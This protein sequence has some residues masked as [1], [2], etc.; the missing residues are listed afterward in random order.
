[1]GEKKSVKSPE[2]MRRLTALLDQSDDAIML[3]ASASGQFHDANRTACQ[4]LGYEYDALL[5]TSVAD[6]QGPLAHPWAVALHSALR[7]SPPPRSQTVV[8]NGQNGAPTIFELTLN[9][10]SFNDS[11]YLLVV[12]HEIPPCDLATANTQGGNATSSQTDPRQVLENIAGYAMQLSLA[13]VSCV[14]TFDPNLKFMAS[15]TSE[16]FCK[17]IA[18]YAKDILQHEAHK[19]RLLE[20]QIVPLPDLPGESDSQLEA[21][22]AK[23]DLH[24]A[25]FVPIPR[26]EQ[27]IGLMFIGQQ[28]AYEITQE[29]L[30]YLQTLAQHSASALENAR[31]LAS[32]AEEKSR[33]EILY[34]LGQHLATTLDIHEVAQ[35][36]LEELATLIHATRSLIIVQSADGHGLELAATLGYTAEARALLER[37]IVESGR[38]TAGWMAENKQT[39]VI[40]EVRT[41]PR[42]NHYPNLDEDIRSSMSVPLIS[43]QTLVGIL[44]LTSDKPAF[45]APCHRQLAESTAAPIAVALTNAQLYRE[46]HRMA[47]DQ[48]LVAEITR[49]L[50]VLQIKSAYPVLAEK[51]KALTGCC[52]IALAMLD[53]EHQHLTMTPL[54]G[55]S[56]DPNDVLREYIIALTDLP[57]Y[58]EMMAG[59][60]LVSMEIDALEPSPLP[61]LNQV[62][63]CPIRGWIGLPLHA[64]GHLIGAL[65]LGYPHVEHDDPPKHAMLWHIANAI[66]I[67]VENSRL[68]QSEQRQ[69]ELAERLQQAA[70]LVNA[71]LDRTE[72]LELIL[73]QLGQVVPND[74]STLQILEDERMRVIA[75][76]NLAGDKIDT[77][78]KEFPLA[79]C[80]YARTLAM[81]DG[82]IIVPDVQ[83]G[84]HPWR[85]FDQAT[86]IRSNIGVSL[87]IR[88][89]VIGA[90]TLDSHQPYAYTEDDARIVQAFAQQAAIAI[91]NARLFAAEQTQREMAEALEAATSVITRTL[92]LDQVLDRILEQTAR[93]VDGDTFN[94]MLIEVDKIRIVRRRGYESIDAELQ[95]EVLH[96]PFET[97]PNL[98]RMLR[99]GRP[100]VTPD[101]VNDPDWISSLENEWRR[102][103]VAAPIHISGETVGF[104]N[105]NGA[106]PNQFDEHDAQRLKAFADHA[107]IA[108]QNARH[109]ERQRHY[110]DELEQRVQRRTMLLQAQKAW[111]EAILSSTT[112]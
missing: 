10:I 35:R 87:W 23:Q 108:I 112:D 72:V 22:L 100:I 45:F 96:Q 57:G 3:I 86:A 109:Y 5:G 2:A 28:Q 21:T 25:L 20:N 48:K 85:I 99:T 63:D 106:R 26:G 94:I 42:W 51:L 16:A 107:A 55:S 44:T 73:D 90:L 56:T 77:Q 71:S 59:K 78:D 29:E 62:S 14:L 15:G 69:R 33:F 91:E 7:V 84:D 79:T 76:R 36:A 111:L 70:V 80:A 38:G 34:R 92:D 95:P 60:S 75:E 52:F 9:H 110:A 81:G 105:V 67:T 17:D 24:A 93:V 39:M 37:Y 11:S 61:W 19:Q 74:S 13:D 50:N 4:L 27:L 88:D 41:D 49:A 30:I 54:T 104:L 64:S 53:D 101:T 1:M 6:L 66:A 18:T 8:H 83:E 31:L 43:G 89:E 82:P 46:A 102:S 97:Y 40:D 98:L 47:R 32:L 103:Y 68:F 65:C 58:Q 12:A